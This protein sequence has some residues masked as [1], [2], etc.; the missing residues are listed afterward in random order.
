ML[1]VNPIVNSTP[2]VQ[3]AHR[4]PNNLVFKGLPKDL[5][6]LSS[7]SKKSAC[8]VFDKIFEFLGI[9]SKSI[10]SRELKIFQS[11]FQ[12][13]FLRGDISAEETMGI[14]ERYRAI[15]NIAD[16]TQYANA[17]YR[18]TK[19][20]FGFEHIDLPLRFKSGKQSGAGTTVGGS[21][22]LMHEVEI[23]PDLSR[24]KL[25]INIF[26]ELR[27]VKQN[28]YAASLN[29]AEYLESVF[30]RLRDKLPES[31][32]ENDLQCAMYLA[33]VKMIKR[34]GKFTPENIPQKDM[35]YAKKC[36]NAHK[37][38]VNPHIDKKAYLENFLE[39]DAYCSEFKFE[40]LYDR[41]RNLV[42]RSN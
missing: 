2:N 24:E 10:T 32:T 16:K 3:A 21:K 27:H 38:Y 15:E 28:Y 6:Q 20:D 34:W 9:K 29:H 26:H 7:S 36:L 14:I 8:S 30:N 5:V 13:L 33:G 4:Q 40:K 25:P 23:S 31:A 12:S 19:K 18:E 22:T 41:L 37:T 17:F 1:C 39:Q 11:E 35:K 42:N